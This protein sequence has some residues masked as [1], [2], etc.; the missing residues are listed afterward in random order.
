MEKILT[1]AGLLLGSM[2]I[3]ICALVIYD[4]FYMRKHPEYSL[5]PVVTTCRLCNKKIYVWQR[6]ESRWYKTTL[7]NPYNIAITVRVGGLVHKKCEGTPEFII[8]AS[9]GRSDDGRR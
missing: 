7:D 4:L 5:F 2:V 8:K 9:F 1:L 6:K 3:I